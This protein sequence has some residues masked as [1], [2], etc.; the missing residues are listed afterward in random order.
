ML[1]ETVVNNFKGPD[2]EEGGRGEVVGLRIIMRYS[3]SMKMYF[4][5]FI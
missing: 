2:K 1:Q 4:V 3:F 5:T